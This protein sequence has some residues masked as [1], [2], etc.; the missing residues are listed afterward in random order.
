MF[1]VTLCVA[2][3]GLFVFALVCAFVYKQSKAPRHRVNGD[4]AAAIADRIVFQFQQ[5]QANKVIG[6]TR[7]VKKR[8]QSFVGRSLVAKKSHTTNHLIRAVFVCFRILT[9]VHLC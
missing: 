8:Q 3:H 1:E 5:L 6:T 7:L 2:L 9:C 4:D